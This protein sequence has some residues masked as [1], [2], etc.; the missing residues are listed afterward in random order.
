MLRSKSFLGAASK[1]ADVAD[2]HENFY[3]AGDGEMAQYNKT[4][5][6]HLGGYWQG[7]SEPSP[8]PSEV[9]PGVACP[10][11][12]NLQKC[13]PAP[14]KTV[15]LK[16]PLHSQQPHSSCTIFSQSYVSQQRVLVLEF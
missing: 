8:Q 10:T 13:L 16:P 7:P 6:E 2:L 14:V 3:D 4:H 5:C 15:E 12:K 1:V 9:G 11:E